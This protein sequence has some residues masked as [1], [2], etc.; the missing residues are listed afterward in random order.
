[1]GAVDVDSFDQEYYSSEGPTN[2]PGGSAT[3]GSIKPDIAGY[4]NVSTASYGSK[5]FPGT[6]A[7]TPHVAGAAA[8][9]M[10]LYL[11][12]T[13]DQVQGYL[14]KWAM[15]QGDPGKDSKFGHGV[16]FLGP[17]MN[18]NMHAVYLLLLLTAK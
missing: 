13:V 14:E 15:E 10:G 4:A 11:H 12:Y 7:A 6:S 16:L 3:G 17:P 2:G 18:A 9:V 1:M 5:N 8:L